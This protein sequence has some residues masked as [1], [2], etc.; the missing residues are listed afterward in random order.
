[1]RSHRL[2]HQNRLYFYVR[3]S[4]LPLIPVATNVRRPNAVPRRCPWCKAKR[5][6]YGIY[7]CGVKLYVDY[8]ARLIGL[9]I[10]C[11]AHIVHDPIHAVNCF[12]VE[13]DY[14]ADII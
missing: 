8:P 3:K 6:E 2:R 10:I 9:Y 14:E 11:I 4:A 13:H 7:K 5:R 1:M 12:E